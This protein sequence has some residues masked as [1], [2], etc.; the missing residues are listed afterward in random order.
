MSN[1]SFYQW[2]AAPASV[3]IIWKVPYLSFIGFH[4]S[5]RHRG[6]EWGYRLYYTIKGRQFCKCQRMSGKIIFSININIY[7]DYNQHN[8]YNVC[9]LFRFPLFRLVPSLFLLPVPMYSLALLV[10]WVIGLQVQHCLLFSH[11]G[12]DWNIV[13]ANRYIS[14]NSGADFCSTSM[15][16]PIDFASWAII[17]LKF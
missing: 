9:S 4:F 11:F 5:S 6:S 8:S 3:W 14:W 2:V 10:V 12:P 17:G 15:R 1:K 13:T 16:K 7:Y